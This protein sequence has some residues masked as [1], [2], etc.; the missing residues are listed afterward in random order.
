MYPGALVLCYWIQHENCILYPG[1]MVFVVDYN[2]KGNVYPGNMILFMNPLLK[3]GL[4]LSSM[5]TCDFRFWCYGFVIEFN[6]KIEFRFMV[7]WFGY[8]IQ[9]ENWISHFGARVLLLNSIQQLNFIPCFFGFLIESNAKL[10]VRNL[11]LG[12]YIERI[13]F[14]YWIQWG[15]QCVFSG[16]LIWLLKQNSGGALMWCYGFLVEFSTHSYPGNLML[17][18][19]PKTDTEIDILVV[20]FCWVRYEN[21]V[22]Y[23][24]AMIL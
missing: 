4:V 7:L 18:L 12:L 2:S 13:R 16:A 6:T 5:R 20:W 3:R 23:S 11:A 24:G 21:Y 9:C 14:C 1:V 15:N 19:K 8:W 17:L 10:Q 22:I